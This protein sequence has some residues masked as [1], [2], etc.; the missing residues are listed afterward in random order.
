[1]DAQEVIKVVE[2]LQ[3]NTSAGIIVLAYYLIV[4]WQKIKD[5]LGLSRD[6]KND[7]NRVEKSYQ[8]LKLRIE[9]EKIKK[10]SD[11][12]NALLAQLEQEMQAS[13]EDKKVEPFTN[14]Q[15]FVAIPLIILVVI[16]S[17]FELQA[18]D[19]HS[20]DTGFDILSGTLFVIT[21]IIIGFWGIPILQNQK[22]GRLRKIGFIAFWTII[23]YI[24]SY[25]SSIIFS[26]FISDTEEI[27]GTTLSLILLFSLLC[28]L[29][30]GIFEKL[31]FM[32]K[33]SSTHRL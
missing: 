2:D 10:D 8:I 30:L 14:V 25:F 4:Y 31:P 5:A 3:T 11:L 24:L 22:K 21:M 1:M 33:N 20:G 23:F 6:N 13:L 7:L 18:I 32:L 26:S 27:S 9:I 17:G 12:D 29:F 16:Q 28:S 15:K 19:Q